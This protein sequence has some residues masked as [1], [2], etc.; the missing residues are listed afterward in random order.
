MKK[1]ENGCEM[2]RVGR[3]SNRGYLEFV[4]KKGQAV[5]DIETLFWRTAM[6]R[7]P[8]DCFLCHAISIAKFA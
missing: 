5:I 7:L 6:K 4:E 8:S 3:F 1:T 2:A